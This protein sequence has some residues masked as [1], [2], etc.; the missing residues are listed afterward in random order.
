MLLD[1]GATTIYVSKTWVEEHRLQISKFSN[2]N[3]K[4]G[5]NQIVESELDVLPMEVLVSGLNDGY[6]CVAVVYAIP[7]EFDCILGIPFFED[8]QPQVNW[9]SRQIEVTIMEALHWKRAGAICEP[10]EEDGLVIA[11]GLRR[12]VGAKGLSA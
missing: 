6:K 11:S 2:K 7:D 4:L 12:S 10:I 9:R 8:M 1:C 5:D 3:F